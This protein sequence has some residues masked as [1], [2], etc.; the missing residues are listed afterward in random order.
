MTGGGNLLSRR[1]DALSKRGVDTENLARANH[2]REQAGDDLMIH[3]R[4]HR[5]DADLSVGKPIPILGR[6]RRPAD[7]PP[8]RARILDEVIEEKLRRLLH[9]RIRLCQEGAIGIEQI[10]LPQMLRQPRRAGG[11][12][13]RSRAIA[14]R[15]ES[16][17]VADVMRHESVG[18]VMHARRLPARLAQRFEI[19]EE[20]LMQLG[21]VR[22]FRRPVI[23]LQVDV[24]VVVAVPRRKHAV[25]PQPLQVRRDP[26]RAAARNQQIAAELKVERFEAEI[27]LT[28][29][30]ALEALVGRHVDTVD[31]VRGYQAAARHGGTASDD[32]RRDPISAF[33]TASLL[34]ADSARSTDAR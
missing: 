6:D 23:H 26:A 22:H 3:R 30:D 24:E 32:R 29:L 15:R 1:R 31:R 14:W 28:L 33:R 19:V 21:E 12:Q 18:A 34:A 16:P 8:W 7:E 11:P 10:V 20:R 2:L 25:V 9:D 17:D 4:P 13:A 27:G 5:Q